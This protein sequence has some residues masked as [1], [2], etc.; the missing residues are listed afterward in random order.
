[1]GAYRRG[2]WRMAA[3]DASLMTSHTETHDRIRDAKAKASARKLVDDGEI[4]L[5]WLLF[6]DPDK[7][8]D[9]AFMGGAIVPAVKDDF[10]GA[11]R[12]AHAFDCNPAGSQVAWIEKPN[13]ERLP[14]SM[15]ARLLSR[16][17]VAQAEA[18]LAGEVQ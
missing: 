18:I 3:R 11:V 5:F 10:L 16:D 13:L 12:V 4:V 9:D 6:E 1:M 17:E 8:G 7:A 2:C 15:L 14:R